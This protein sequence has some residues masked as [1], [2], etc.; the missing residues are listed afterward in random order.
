MPNAKRFR[1]SLLFPAAFAAA[2]GIGVGACGEDSSGEEWTTRQADV[3]LVSLEAANTP[4]DSPWTQS[5]TSADPPQQVN[6]VDTSN[7]SRTVSGDQIG[8]TAVRPIGWCATA[9]S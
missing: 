6:R 8:L 1:Q 3:D 7:A 9:T 5:V 2:I 4:G